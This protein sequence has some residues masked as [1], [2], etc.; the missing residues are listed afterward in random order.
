[1]EEQ[2]SYEDCCT[3]LTTLKADDDSLHAVENSGT[4]N[5]RASAT[6]H[7]DRASAIEMSELHDADGLLQFVRNPQA[8]TAA[9]VSTG[10]GQ[11]MLEWHRPHWSG[12]LILLLTA[13]VGMICGLGIYLLGFEFVSLKWLALHIAIPVVAEIPCSLWLCVM[14]LLTLQDM[15]RLPDVLRR[16]IIPWVFCVAV[17]CGLSVSF[18]FSTLFGPTTEVWMIVVVLQVSLYLAHVIV[19]L[20]IALLKKPT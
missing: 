5:S 1:M 11:S 7:E 9:S 16:E 17:L 6:L 14:A 4:N 10:A 20:G 2:S 15:A 3:F 13:L 18:V 8:L 12:P 19:M